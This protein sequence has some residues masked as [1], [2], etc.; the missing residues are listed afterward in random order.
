M[1]RRKF[2]IGAGSTAIGASAL[3]GSGAFNFANVER[4]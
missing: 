3:V 1:E 2:L 4:V